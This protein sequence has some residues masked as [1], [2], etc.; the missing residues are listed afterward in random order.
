[1]ETGLASARPQV[2]SD[3]SGARASDP[4]RAAGVDYSILDE[5]KRVA[6]AEALETSALLTAHG[7]RAIDESRGSSA[8]LF[9]LGGRTLALVVEGLGTKSIVAR[10]V[11][12][13]TRVN[14]FRDIAYDTVAAIVNDLCSVGAIPLVV[15]AYFATGS[16]D[17]YRDRERVGELLHGWR[18]GCED[19]G[20]TWGGGESP[21]LHGLVSAEDIELAGSA[22]G[23]IP[24][25]AAPILG[26][27]LGPGDEIVLVAS[28][29]LHANGASLARA[30]ASRLDDGYATKIPGGET[31][32]EALLRPSHIYARL[33][34]AAV[35]ER[36]PITYLSHITGHGLLKIMRPSR[37]LTYRLTE[38]PP[39]PPV[40][41]FL[42]DAAE[43]EPK[44]AYATLN[45]GSGYAV[46]CR[47][48]SAGSVVELAAT[49][50]LDA[51]LAGAVEE[52]PRRVLVEPLGIAYDGEEMPIAAG[53]P[54]PAIDD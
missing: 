41:S 38:L 48:G 9:E 52:G 1:M 3:S 36:L 47:P 42:V 17:W 23:S 16:S 33:V 45:M 51:R 15:N 50:G 54:P 5:G 2:V 19:A 26:D 12:A 27:R 34:A 40:L 7:G 32:G 25:G 31:F 21:S 13:E 39:V 14:R 22:V 46:Y 29:G 8:F 28:T 18:S 30:V 4:Y 53:G 6:L 10:Q 37:P 35:A 49:L 11:Y 43:L 24:D 20:C 44:Q